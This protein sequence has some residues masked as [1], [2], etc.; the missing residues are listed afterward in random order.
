VQKLL[1]KMD[2]FTNNE[3]LY[4]GRESNLS[5]EQIKELFNDDFSGIDD[6]IKL[7]L[8]YDGIFFPKQAMM[9]RSK[10]YDVQKGDWDKIEVGFFL[11]FNDII[12]LRDIQ[13]QDNPE[14]NSFTLSHIPFADD[15]F[16]NDIWIETSTGLI[17]VLY[18]EY[19]LD[20]GLIIVAPNFNDFCSS[21]E[22]WK[23]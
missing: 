17:K 14:L 2:L 1:L 16:G 19:E 15:G 13:K 5:I 4:K 22:N 20:E 10:F 6:F 18:H 11:K 3:L 9:F 12:E 8:T 23:M 21:L 7:Y